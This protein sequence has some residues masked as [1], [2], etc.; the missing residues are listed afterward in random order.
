MRPFSNI[1]KLMCCVVTVRQRWRAGYVRRVRGLGTERGGG[2]VLLRETRDCGGY[3]LS[4][5]T[6]HH[7]YHCHRYRRHSNSY[8]HSCFPCRYRRSRLLN[9][10]VTESVKYIRLVFTAATTDLL[11]INNTFFYFVVFHYI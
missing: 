5:T 8:R 6:N 11:K 4:S 10:T 9:T 2:A 7:G 1:V 3:T